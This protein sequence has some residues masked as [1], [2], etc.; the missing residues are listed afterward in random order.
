M[1]FNPFK[2]PQ[3]SSRWN[4][5]K[6]NIESQI[7]NIDN[8]IDNKNNSKF[9]LNM[10]DNDKYTS[11]DNIFRNS[12]KNIRENSFL[13]KHN[14]RDTYNKNTF[15]NGG[16]NKDT[17]GENN[18]GERKRGIFTSYTDDYIDD[19]TESN[20]VNSNKEQKEPD[21]NNEEDFPSLG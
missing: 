19:I 17:Y 21:I 11:E 6:N 9:K 8:N 20:T 5:L 12:N 14:N 10:V 2:P 3:T 4:A 15:T 7:E 1:S 16:F 13:N 18:M